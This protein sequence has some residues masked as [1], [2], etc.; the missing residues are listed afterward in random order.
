LIMWLVKLVAWMMV[1]SGW[2]RCRWRSIVDD[3]GGAVGGHVDAVGGEL[4]DGGHD[5]DE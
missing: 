1:R 2:S 4:E 5:P 3:V